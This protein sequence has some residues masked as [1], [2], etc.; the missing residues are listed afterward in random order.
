M[1]QSLPKPVVRDFQATKVNHGNLTKWLILCQTHPVSLPHC[2]LIASHLEHRPLIYLQDASF[3]RLLTQG[4][5]F[6]LLRPLGPM[7][8][9]VLATLIL[10]YIM[11]RELHSFPAQGWAELTF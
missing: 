6:L 9:L 11:D 3:L 5:L 10:P 8:I 1:A 2:P 4:A 7:A